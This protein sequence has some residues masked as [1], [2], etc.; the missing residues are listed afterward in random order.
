FVVGDT[1]TSSVVVNNNTESALSVRP[2]LEVGGVLSGTR[3]EAAAVLKVAPNGE[4]RADWVL[5][6]PKPG[7][8]K[9]KVTGRGGKYSD[10]MEKTY[11]AYAHGIEQFIDKS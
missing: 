11:V 2:E 8:V 10:A 7:E 4:A 5:T 3:L 1:V 6:I 9:L